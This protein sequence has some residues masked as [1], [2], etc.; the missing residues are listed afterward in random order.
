MKGK[1]GTAK[2]KQPLFLFAHIH[3][4]TMSIYSGVYITNNAR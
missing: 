2:L 1:I 4:V 3:R